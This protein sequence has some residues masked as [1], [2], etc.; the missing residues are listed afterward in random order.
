MAHRVNQQVA[1][2]VPSASLDYRNRYNNRQYVDAGPKSG[3]A[4]PPPVQAPMVIS[5]MTG[6]FTAQNSARDASTVRDRGEAAVTMFK[7][8]VF[9]GVVFGLFAIV[10][11][12]Q[13]KDMPWFYWHPRWFGY[14]L[15]FLVSILAIS[16][17]GYKWIIYKVFDDSPTALEKHRIDAAA[18]RD[19]EAI[20]AQT[21]IHLVEYGV[22]LQLEEGEDRFGNPTLFTT[23]PERRLAE[24]EPTFAQKVIRRIAG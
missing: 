11:L 23:P 14:V 12:Y 20:H 5:D 8:V 18:A 21:I 10:L 9:L 16:A 7:P 4:G 22:S 24:R 2:G 13:V 15:V 17:Y 3:K 6:A 19:A 1:T